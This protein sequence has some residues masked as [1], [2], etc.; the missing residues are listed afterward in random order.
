MN[1]KPVKQLWLSLMVRDELGTYDL[2]SENPTGTMRLM[3]RIVAPENLRAALRRVRKNEGAPG[4]D[5]MTVERVGRAPESELADDPR[6]TA[7]RSL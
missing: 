4:V 5:G 7:R 2:S 1:S 6:A 3:E